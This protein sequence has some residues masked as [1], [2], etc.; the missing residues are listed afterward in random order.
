ML[1]RSAASLP[2]LLAL[3]FIVVL[4]MGALPSIKVFGLGFLVSSEWDA[5]EGREQ[6]GALAF[7]YGTIFSSLF[8]LLIA[9][10][11][12]IGVA[13]FLSEVFRSRFRSVIAFLIEVLA[14]IPSIVYGMWGFYVMVP[15]VEKYV[16]PPVQGV[17][18]KEF[19]LFRGFSG[20]SL[21]SGG[22]I[23]A[24]MILPVI[25]SISYDAIR[26]VPRSY[27]E[28][29]IGLGAT[30]WEMIRLAV[31]PAARSGLIASC[32]LALGRAM[33]ETMAITMVIG[34]SYIIQWSL[35]A[36]ANTIASAIA[37]Q[38]SEASGLQLSA[39]IELALLLFLMTLTVNALAR[40]I[41]GRLGN[42][43]AALT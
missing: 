9:A 39:L 18:G 10:P 25:V 7:I 34:N 19:I 20:L 33:G 13:T 8:A 32:I 4:V 6:Y 40:Y 23:L 1:L 43:K 36:S 28:A 41:L 11:V 26:S 24:V 12:G 5:S 16:M 37:S 29:A 17:F 2:I 42:R 14:T 35:F 31:W 15:W 22:L 21:F 30:R 3:L 38:F 27:R